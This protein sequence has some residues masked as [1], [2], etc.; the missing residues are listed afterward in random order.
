MLSMYSLCF[1]QFQHFKSLL[2][3][4]SFAGLAKCADKRDEVVPCPSLYVQT[5]AAS[6]LISAHIFPYGNLGKF[7]SYF[8]G[9]GRKF[10]LG[11]GCLFLS[12]VL[13][14]TSGK[15]LT[16][17]RENNFLSSVC[18]TDMAWTKGA[19]GGKRN[20]FLHSFDLCQQRWVVFALYF[21]TA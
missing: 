9:K 16:W 13:L 15:H 19:F 8:T 2:F 14:L 4:A 10:S 11:D 21:V 3:L 6:P 5:G 1:H 12:L 7:L 17:E 18:V 20:A